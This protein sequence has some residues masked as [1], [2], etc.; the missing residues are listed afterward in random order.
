MGSGPLLT[1]SAMVAI[2]AASGEP[3]GA[4]GAPSTAT[5]GAQA[6]APGAVS[7]ARDAFRSGGFD[8]GHPVGGTFAIT[9]PRE[10]FERF[11]GIGL[12]DDGRGGV[13]VVGGDQADPRAVPSDRLPASLGNDV[14]IVTFTAPP[15][16]GPGNP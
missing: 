13:V 16:F 8:V 12:A 1:V 11:F 7:R 10:T 9:A 3:P 14:A 6:P 4:R 5:L 15:D 2:A